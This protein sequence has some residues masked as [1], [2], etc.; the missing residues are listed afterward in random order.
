[1]N[2]T[3]AVNH[4]LSKQRF[5]NNWKRFFQRGF[6]PINIQHLNLNLCP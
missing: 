6:T 2:I 4:H 3:S 5:I 1:M